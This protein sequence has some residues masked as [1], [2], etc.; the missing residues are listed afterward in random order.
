MRNDLK[1]L[2]VLTLA[3]FAAACA[4][5]TVDQEAAV[6]EEEQPQAESRQPAPAAATPGYGQQPAAAAP[7]QA[8]RPSSGQQAAPPPPPEPATIEV[9]AGTVL[10][11]ETMRRIT[12]AKIQPGDRFRASTIVPVVV[13]NEVAIPVG[14]IIRGVITEAVSATRM[15][16]QASLTLSFE[17]LRLPDGQE[18]PIS[19]VLT[20]EGKEIGKRTAGIVGGSAA[21]GAVLGKIIGKDTKGAVAGALVGAAVGTGIAAAQEGQELDL[22]KGTGVAVELKAPIRVAVAPEGA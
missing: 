17:E 10:E 19:A 9:P 21:G 22:P 13:G 18:V 16:G 20:Q 12:T 3:V 1:A 15:K 8:A 7:T 5:A 4:G 2:A 14:T 6:E 11:A